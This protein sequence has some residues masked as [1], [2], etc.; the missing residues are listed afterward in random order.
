MKKSNVSDKE[1]LQFLFECRGAIIGMIDKIRKKCPIAYALC[2]DLKCL[3]PQVILFEKETELVKCFTNVL[4]FVY[5]ADLIDFQK[6][7]D[8]IHEYGEFLVYAKTEADFLKFMKYDSNSR[9]DVLFKKHMGDNMQFTHCWIIVNKVL[10]LSHVQ[11]S[12]ERGFSTNKEMLRDNMQD[13][14]VVALRLVKDYLDRHGL[15]KIVI[16]KEMITSVARARSRYLADLELK[17]EESKKM[18]K[19]LK[20]K[21]LEEEIEVLQRKKKLLKTEHLELK[22]KSDKFLDRAQN[23]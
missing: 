8:A 22:Q 14:T 3:D 15:Q 20:R 11:A 16:N 17:K 19:I 7:D 12:V 2:R 10:L 21:P 4:K 9:L 1:K 5:E 18:N 6:C 13:D 23:V